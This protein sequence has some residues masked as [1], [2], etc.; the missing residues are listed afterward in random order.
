MFVFVDGIVV[1]SLIF[2]E[3]LRRLTIVCTWLSNA[4][5]QLNRKKR[6]FSYNTISSWLRAVLNTRLPWH[7]KYSSCPRVSGA[8]YSSVFTNLYGT[9]LIH[10]SLILAI[11]DDTAPLPALPSK[12]AKISWI[13]NGADVLP[14]LEAVLIHHLSCAITTRSYGLKFKQMRAMFF[15]YWHHFRTSIQ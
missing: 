7:R 10:S 3:H 1:C 15:F 2:F 11:A 5:C 8:S 9:L 14:Q 6:P 12:G 13:S 4:S